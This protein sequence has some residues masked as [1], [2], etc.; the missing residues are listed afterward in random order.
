MTTQSSAKKEKQQPSKFNLW[1]DTK[2]S[3][4]TQKRIMTWGRRLLLAGILGLLVY[5]LS[6]I[7]WTNIWHNI[8]SQPLFYVVFVGM[9]LGTPLAETFIY[10]L[11]WGLSFRQVFPV[12]LKKRVLN[13]DVV[14]YSGEAN[15]FLWVRQHL[16]RSDRLILRDIKDNTVISSLTSM[17]IALGLLSTFL[18][19]GLLPLDGLISELKTGWIIG[20]GFCLLLFIALAI[21]F[22][23]IV[24]AFPGTLV[25][26]LFGIHVGRLM[27]VQTLQVVQWAVVMPAVPLTAWFIPLSAYIVVNQIPIIPSKNLLVVA[28]SAELAGWINTSESAIA[29][30]FLVA[31][32]L[33]KVVNF[34]LF[35]Y[36]STRT[37]KD[38]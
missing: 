18:F 8:P 23:N 29:G 20:G 25:R 37:G 13:K 17:L 22:R 7:G 34:V 15:L 2:V 9:Y 30:M 14:N 5:R 4:Q 3:K 6:D 38:V 11:I 10:S 12:M 27:F 32:V 26:K 33:D 31:A 21:R 28:A 35:S 36:L 24:I 1:L 16:D 19:T